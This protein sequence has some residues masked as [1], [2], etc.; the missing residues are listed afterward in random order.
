MENLLK[1]TI[2]L[3]LSSL[4]LVLI[5]VSCQEEHAEL[6]TLSPPEVANEH[7]I[8]LDMAKDIAKEVKIRSSLKDQSLLPSG[9][10]AL[11]KDISEV[12]EIPDEDGL[13]ALYIINFSDSSYVMLAADDR[14]S[15]IKSFS[16][17]H[18]F[19]LNKEKYP[20][21]L[22]EWL[23]GTSESI[24]E[25]R[26]L[27]IEQSDAV[28]STWNLEEMKAVISPSGPVEEGIGDKTYK[29][30]ERGPLLSTTWSQGRG[31]NN[32]APYVPCGT[33]VSRALTGCVAIAIAQVINYHQ[34]P[35]WYD[36]D[37]MPDHSGSTE[38]SKLMKN[39]GDA[40]D[41]DWGCDESSASMSN[42]AP[43]FLNNFNY[44]S[45]SDNNFNYGTAEREIKYRRP[46]ILSGG[47][48]GRDCFAGIFCYDTYENGHAWVCDGYK[49][50]TVT[51]STFQYSY[52]YLHMNWGWG[53][54]WNDWY[55]FN[56][57]SPSNRSY[58]YRKRMIYNI[59]P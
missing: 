17:E 46:V 13:A 27:D 43:A 31:Y 39:A 34:Y 3:R 4:L 14:T 2:L 12:F 58:N 7:F 55:S 56:D 50:N 6:S 21:G 30:E 59:R 33:G 32:Q 19:P 16:L 26:Q 49:K 22:V 44:F 53:G 1:K 29:F 5:A 52:K 8:S 35:N 28:A 37:A 47:S 10:T 15:P 18:S 11:F 9:R 57:W 38:V 20:L 45:A 40:V 23:M 42:V 36:W 54:G 48:K 25:I 24:S 51:S 41:M